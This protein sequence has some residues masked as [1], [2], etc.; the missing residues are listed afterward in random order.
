M[1]KL[2]DDL[3]WMDATAQAD[4]VKRGEITPGELVDAA[5]ARIE[6]LN[7]DLNAVIAPLFDEGRR[8]AAEPNLVETPFAG[9][10]FLLKDL[11]ASQAGQTMTAGNAALRD[12]GYVTHTDSPLGARFRDAGLITLG[13]TNASEF[14]AQTTTQPVAYGPTRNPWDLERSPSGSSGG[15]A[16]AVAAGMVP[17][18]HAGDG[19]GS[20]RTPAAW[21]GLAGLKPSRGRVPLPQGSVSRIVCELAITRTVRDTARLLDAVCGNQP[22]ELFLTPSPE[23]A[24]IQDVETDP[25]AL[26][27]GLMTDI[28]EA[29]TDPECRKAVE[30]TG[31]LLEDLGHHV[32]HAYPNALNDEE[33]RP[34]TVALSRAS[35]R[36]TLE[37]LGR[38]LGRDVRETD[39][40]PY[41]WGLAEWDQPE[42]RAQDYIRATEWLQAWASRV[43]G[44][45]DTGFDLL[46]TPTVHTPAATL[47]EMTPPADAPWK[48]PQV[49]AQLAFTQPFNHTGQPAISLPLH[50]TPSGPPVGIQL[51]AAYGREDVLLQVAGQLERAKPWAHRHPD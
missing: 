16:A 51:I 46:L 42:V 23:K 31:R 17:M 20:I 8:W 24:F 39:V 49:R 29:E 22:G 40:E 45:W 2:L 11:G 10:P 43:A 28:I 50:W 18:A 27:G 48:L 14:G 7:P 32:E 47:E 38:M 36:Y 26:R 1:T 6:V 30:D 37:N 25:G 19:G 35:F 3:R 9:V 44:W 41:L 21:C 4:L 13:K 34:N 33:R 12:A 15:S 5:I